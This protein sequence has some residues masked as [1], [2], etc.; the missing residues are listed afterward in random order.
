MK[1]DLLQSGN[2]PICKT[3]LKVETDEYIGYKSKPVNIYKLE[4][5]VETKCPVCKRLIVDRR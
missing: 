5:K 3:K 4:R 2:C 1:Y